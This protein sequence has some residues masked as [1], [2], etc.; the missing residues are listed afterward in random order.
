MANVRIEKRVGMKGVFLGHCVFAPQVTGEIRRSHELLVRKVSLPEGVDSEMLF[1]ALYGQSNLGAFWLDS[2]SSQGKYSFMGD[3]SGPMG[4]VV[5]YITATTDEA[6]QETL[7]KVRRR[8]GRVEV[9]RGQ[10]VL[11]YLKSQV[12]EVR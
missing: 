9:H 7:L 8:D 12:S 4:H 2:S 10:S 6:A 5:E 11:A 1:R 3:A